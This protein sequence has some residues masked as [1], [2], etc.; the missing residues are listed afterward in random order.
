M[1][2]I[3]IRNPAS[4]SRGEREGEKEDFVQRAEEGR[5]EVEPLAFVAQ[6]WL[7]V[8]GLILAMGRVERDAVDACVV[9]EQMGIASEA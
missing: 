7:V 2:C 3:A 1:S 4:R 8:R 9:G 6:A 5:E